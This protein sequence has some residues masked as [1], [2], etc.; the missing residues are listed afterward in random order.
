MKKPEKIVPCLFLTLIL[1]CGSSD[2]NFNDASPGPDDSSETTS[3]S[4]VRDT[5]VI[6]TGAD[7]ASHNEG[8]DAE[9]PDAADAGQS[10]YGVTADTFD[11]G[12]TDTGI[13]DAGFPDGTVADAAS[14]VSDVSV[15]DVQ[16]ASDS[17][18]SEDGA[19]EPSDTN[20]L[21]NPPDASAVD[22]AGAE[23]ES[24]AGCTPTCVNKC[25][26]LDGCGGVCPDT[27]NPPYVCGSG[28]NKDECGSGVWEDA[29][30]GLEWI[31]YPSAIK[32]LNW[33]P[34]MDYCNALDFAGHTD[35][36]FPTVSELRS[37]VS[38]CAQTQTGGTCAASDLCLWSNTCHISA[39]DGC[40]PKGGPGNNGCYW[41]T[42]LNGACD[43]YYWT[44]SLDASVLGDVWEIHFSRGTID[45]SPKSFPQ[46]TRCVRNISV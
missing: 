39:C 37:L 13:E 23:V 33:Q 22:A 31:N 27:C 2:N 15:T 3:D 34:A 10:D 18:G 12:M 26:G 35:W 9:Q 44:S 42:E 1:G 30:S 36:R 28:I 4:G 6:D 19:V 24:D 45:T 38:G 20:D 11:A 14:D 21:G 29:A 16:E 40:L 46:Y 17:G 8:H 32:S 7:A 41:P 43:N 25:S 5:A